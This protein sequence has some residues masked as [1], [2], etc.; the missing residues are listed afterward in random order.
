MVGWRCRNRYHYLEH[1]WIG[2]SENGILCACNI[3]KLNYIQSANGMWL[4]RSKWN[5]IRVCLIKFISKRKSYCIHTYRIQQNEKK[6][7]WGMEKLKWKMKVQTD[8]PILFIRNKNVNNE[9]KF[10]FGGLSKI[11]CKSISKLEISS[12]L[13]KIAWNQLKF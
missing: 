7:R 9:T 10:H 11:S 2:L 5:E 13:P 12:I 8:K 6:T 4:C 3:P 1:H